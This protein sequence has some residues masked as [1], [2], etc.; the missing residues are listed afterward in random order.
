[1]IIEY[2]ACRPKLFMWLLIQN[3]INKIV[4]VLRTCILNLSLRLWITSVETTAYTNKNSVTVI[5]EF[6]KPN[7]L[8]QLNSCCKFI[9]KFDLKFQQMQTKQL[10]KS[11]DF[12]LNW[13][14]KN[15]N[16]FQK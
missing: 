4:N 15:H 7:K 10:Y 9:L 14:N 11:K 12:L 13:T 8:K 3:P 6:W 1:M 5:G 2:T 16:G